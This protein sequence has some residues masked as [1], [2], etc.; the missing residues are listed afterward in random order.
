MSLCSENEHGKRS[1]RHVRNSGVG[2]LRFSNIVN[3]VHSEG[4]GVTGLVAEIVNEVLAREFSSE[5]V[6]GILI[7]SH[8]GVSISVRVCVLVQD[9]KVVRVD[10]F[11][12]IVPS[13]GSSGVV[14]INVL[15]LKSN[16]RIGN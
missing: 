3:S 16:E 8:V 1:S 6:S 14:G 12:R 9:L 5:L 2:P 11:I 7:I 15:G 4:D 13:D 10:S